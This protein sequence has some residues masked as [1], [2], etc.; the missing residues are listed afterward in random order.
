M[1]AKLIIVSGQKLQHF[2]TDNFF[3]LICF[4]KHLL[5]SHW[6]CLGMH[7]L[8]LK[9]TVSEEFKLIRRELQNCYT[10]LVDGLLLVIQLLVLCL[11]HVLNPNANELF[12][13]YSAKCLQSLML[14]TSLNPVSFCKCSLLHS[15]ISSLHCLIQSILPNSAENW[16][17][18][19]CRCRQKGSQRGN[20]FEGDDSFSLY[21]Q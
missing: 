2:F 4:L 6:D 17:R 10:R 19:C 18:Q 7:L 12:F 16:L 5:D 15:Y 1:G 3:F 21:M 13:W 11:C 14:V 8:P 20:Y 9:R